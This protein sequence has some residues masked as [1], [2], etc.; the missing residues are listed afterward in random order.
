MFWALIR[1][2]TTIETPGK[3]TNLLETCG[4]PSKKEVN[5]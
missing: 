4:H 1:S 2:I 3:T 5:G